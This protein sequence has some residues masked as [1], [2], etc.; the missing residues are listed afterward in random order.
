MI[1][2]C[3][4]GR[5]SGSGWSGTRRSRRRC[6]PRRSTSV[7]APTVAPGRG[8][9]ARRSRSAVARGG[10][11]RGRRGRGGR[12]RP[13][14]S[15]WASPSP[16]ASG[17]ASASGLAWRR[18]CGVGVA[19]GVRRRRRRPGWGRGR[20]GRRQLGAQLIGADIAGGRAIA[21]AIE[22]LCFATLVH[23]VDGRRGACRV[24]AGVDGRIAD[25]GLERVG[26]S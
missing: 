24:V 1:A 4:G 20:R 3:G 10:G 7:V 14:G 5:R 17:F 16:S 13:A 8:R 18:A 15:A 23:V 12:A 25:H 6:S 22:E 21:V 19:V 11:G 2:T 26:A 9:A